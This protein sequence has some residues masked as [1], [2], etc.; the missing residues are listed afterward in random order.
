[1]KPEHKKMQREIRRAFFA[2]DVVEI[3]GSGVWLPEDEYDTE[4]DRAMSMLV[5]G[6]AAD[7]VAARITEIIE[8]DWGVRISSRKRQLLADALARYAR[9]DGS[10]QDR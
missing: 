2:C 10:L 6:V 8:R 1:M 5:K 9:I 7:E 4:A 3:G